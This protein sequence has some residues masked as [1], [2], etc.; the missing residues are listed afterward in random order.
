MDTSNDKL[1]RL[2]TRKRGSKKEKKKRNL[3]KETE[4][5]LIAAQNKALKTNYIK[6]KTENTQKNR[7]CCLCSDRD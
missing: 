6:V 1:G 4:S 3:K 5:L 7:K 2:C